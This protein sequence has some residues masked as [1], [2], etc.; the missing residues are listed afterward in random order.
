MHSTRAHHSTTPQYYTNFPPSRHSTAP[1]T[2]LPASPITYRHDRHL[3]ISYPLPSTSLSLSHR[4]L[5]CQPVSTS[6]HQHTLNKTTHIPINITQFHI[7]PTSVAQTL[8]FTPMIVTSLITVTPTATHYFAFTIVTPTSLSLT[9]QLT[10]PSILPPR[11]TIS[12][13]LISLTLSISHHL[14]LYIVAL[15]VLYLFTSHYI[16]TYYILPTVAP[17]NTTP[18]TNM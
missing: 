14:Q 1:T 4:T 5:F 10:H 15:P 6:Y 3:L 16:S 18:S 9:K 7:S 8:P 13:S 2:V 12:T 17:H 11:P